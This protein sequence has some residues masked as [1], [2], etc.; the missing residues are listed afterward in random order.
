MNLENTNFPRNTKII[1]PTIYADALSY[2]ENLQILY[3]SFNDVVDYINTSLEEF[4]DESKQYTDESINQFRF[5]VEVLTSQLQENYVSFISTVNAQLNSI[6]SRL[7]Q[8]DQKINSGLASIEG[9]VQLRISQ[10]NEY[11]FDKIN[12]ELIDV[13]VIN[14]FTGSIVSVQD[15]FDYLAEFHLEN[16]INYLQ[17]ATRDISYTAYVN[18]NMSYTDLAQNGATIIN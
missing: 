4:N 5:E 7:T 10:N 1:L 2:Y 9:M 15:M 14:Y 18:L 13:K 12:S 17:L 16:A 11:I 3:K 6:N 8:Q